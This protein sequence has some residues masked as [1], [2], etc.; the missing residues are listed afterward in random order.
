MTDLDVTVTDSLDPGSTFGEHNAWLRR[1]CFL[2]SARAI[3]QQRCLRRRPYLDCGPVV[4]TSWA[5]QHCIIMRARPASANVRTCRI[6][7][8]ILVVAP[9]ASSVGT[10]A[11]ADGTR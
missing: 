11:R 7:V 9:I 4:G 1:L 6:S 10:P 5:R 2:G 8:V 3:R